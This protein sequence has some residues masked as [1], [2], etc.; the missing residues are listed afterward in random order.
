MPAAQSHDFLCGKQLQNP[1]ALR[2]SA[3]AKLLKDFVVVAS[4][5][6]K[7]LLRSRLFSF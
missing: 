7:C 3:A 6:N 4:G 2:A 5:E 1:S